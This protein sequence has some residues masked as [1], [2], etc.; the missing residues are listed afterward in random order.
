[1][2]YTNIQEAFLK[3]HETVPRKELTELFNAE[4]GT[5]RTHKA[6]KGKCKA[7]GLKTGRNGCFQKGQTPPNKG[8]KGVCKANKTSFKKGNTP[9]N[10]KK[11]GSIVLHK[12]KDGYTYMR[13]KVAEPNSWQMLHACIWEHKH[14]KIPEGFC[15]IFKDRNTFNTSLNNLMLV[16]RS[17]LSRLNKKYSSIDT[18]LREVALQV[19]KL[20]HE[21]IKKG[22]R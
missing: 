13:I 20:Q 9:H 14:G 6:I 10:A 1:M 18:S 5:Q 8:T 2:N 15:V 17:E 16:S 7:L 21:V 4:F 19:V 11:V 12:D 3:E 22:K